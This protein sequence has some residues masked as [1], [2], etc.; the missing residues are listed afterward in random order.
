M[1]AL[2]ISVRGF[3]SAAD[4]R[5]FIL[6]LTAVVLFIG[7]FNFW[8]SSSILLDPSQRL[9]EQL[10]Y[11]MNRQEGRFGSVFLNPNMMGAFAVWSS[12]WPSSLR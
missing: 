7:A 2:A 10:K 8:K 5:R 3:R 9:V 4:Y 1:V 6:H 11:Y 12:R